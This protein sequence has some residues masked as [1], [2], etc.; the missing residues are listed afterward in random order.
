MNEKGKCINKDC[1]IKQY[2]HTFNKESEGVEKRYEF[3]IINGN[4]IGCGYF[5]KHVS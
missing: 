5:K 1:P 3:F 2:C 4:H